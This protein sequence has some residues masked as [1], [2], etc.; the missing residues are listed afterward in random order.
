M[1]RQQLYERADTLLHIGQKKVNDMVND[2]VARD[3]VEVSHVKR[4]KMRDAVLY[5]KASN[6]NGTT[7]KQP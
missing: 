7:E 6:R 4:P 3:L 5:R 1:T 2:L